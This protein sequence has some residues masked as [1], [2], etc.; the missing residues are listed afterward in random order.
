MQCSFKEVSQVSST[1]KLPKS[2]DAMFIKHHIIGFIYVYQVSTSQTRTGI[3][4]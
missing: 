3:F 2:Q 1:K 4:L